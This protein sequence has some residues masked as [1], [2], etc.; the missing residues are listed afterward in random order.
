M[1]ALER[2]EEVRGGEIVIHNA[3]R[4][5]DLSVLVS[6]APIRKGGEIIAAVSVFQ[7][8][9]PLRAFE[10]ERTEFFSMASH[11]IRT[12]VTAIQLQLELALRQ[13]AKGDSTR[14]QELVAK[15]RQ[16]TKALT[17]LINDLLDV[18][19]LDAGRFALDLEEI[20]LG[21]L[22]RKAVEDYPTDPEHPILVVSSERE[23][24]VRADARRIV[25][26]LENLISNSVKYSPRGGTVTVEIGAHDEQA[27]VRI[28]DEGI[29]IPESERTQIFD[30]FFRTSLAKPYGGVGLGL[31]IS[32]EI[33]TRLGGE[34]VLESTGPSG[35]VFRF[36]LPLVRVP[37][38]AVSYPDGRHDQ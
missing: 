34:L 24:P 6:A 21:Q 19:R 31:Y 10:K 37:S 32:R 38:S 23:L 5:A 11:E 14:V 27:F 30:R 7:D 16:R 1:R 26:V 17:G 36:S 4:D 12:P 35:S 28:R 3:K 33:V 13:M 8:I 2:G 22:A 18:T 29:G 9:T 25:E 15:A 20:D